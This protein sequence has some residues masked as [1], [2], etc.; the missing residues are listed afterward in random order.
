MEQNK[1]KQELLN[2]CLAYMKYGQ[3]INSAHVKDMIN[4]A[5]KAGYEHAIANYTEPTKLNS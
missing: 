3:D 2:E 4:K 1:V 5:F